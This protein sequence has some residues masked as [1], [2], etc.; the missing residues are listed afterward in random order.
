M[1][2]YERE[3]P[4]IHNNPK[5]K[6]HLIYSSYH[7]WWVA[8]NDNCM[9]KSCTGRARKNDYFLGHHHTPESIEKIRLS[10]KGEKHPMFGKRHKPETIVKMSGRIPWNKGKPHTKETIEKIKEKIKN[11]PS[12]SEET[13]NKLRNKNQNL[14]EETRYKLRMGNIKAL[15][16]K[17]IV[18]NIKGNNYNPKACEF[19]D[20]LNK[21]RGW[22]LQH[23]LNGGEVE[24][25]GYFPDGYDKERNIIFEYDEPFHYYIN[26]ILKP[27][28]MCRQKRLIEN[29]K[30]NQFIRYDER[31]NRLYDALTNQNIL[32]TN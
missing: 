3:C 20:N 4:N 11:R 26:G 1:K 31:K 6:K 23:A 21:E 7:T 29:H 24:V 9:C 10:K 5:C 2:K 28:D 13:R 19:I 18:G 30:P 15:R 27:R 12:I 8:N 22:N 32:P 14:S 16:K 25:Y 17:G